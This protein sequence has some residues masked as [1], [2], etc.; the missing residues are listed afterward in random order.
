MSQKDIT[1]IFSEEYKAPEF[2][3][4]KISE[5]YRI[6]SCL[7]YTKERQVYLLERR[8]DKEKFILKC[9]NGR[10]GDLLKREYDIVGELADKSKDL[11]RPIDYFSVDDRHFYIRE[12]AEG[13]TL[14]SMIER[15]VRFSETEICFIMGEICNQVHFFHSQNPPV[16]CRDINPQNIIICEDGKP[17]IIDLDSLREYDKSASS[18]TI[19]V[20]TKEMAA[21]EQFGYTQTNVR[22]D[23]YVLGMLLV[24]ITTG[25]YDKYQ[26]MPV[27]IGRIAAK[28]TSFNPAD[29]YSSALAMKKALISRRKIKPA[30]ILSC[31]AAAIIVTA[32]IIL[33][34]HNDIQADYTPEQVISSASQT[35]TAVT[36][37]QRT[38]TSEASATTSLTTTSLTVTAS[39]AT[40]SSLT[41]A[42]TA[43]MTTPANTTTTF[44]ETAETAEAITTTAETSVATALTTT[45]P[46]TTAATTIIT[47]AN[48]VTTTTTAQISTDT[49]EATVLSTEETKVEF[50]QDGQWYNVGNGT[51]KLY[52]HSAGDEIPLLHFDDIAPESW[53]NVRT[54]YAGVTIEGGIGEC[55]MGGTIDG[56]YRCTEPYNCGEHTATL[57]FETGGKELL[58]PKI[59]FWWAGAKTTITVGNIIFSEEEYVL[60]E[61]GAWHCDESGVYTYKN[62]DMETVTYNSQVL[63]LYAEDYGITNLSDVQKV[64]LDIETDG[65]AKVVLGGDIPTFDLSDELTVNNEKKTLTFETNGN[66]GRSDVVMYFWTLAANVNVRVDNIKFV[67]E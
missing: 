60:P 6:L 29:R 17:R 47:S 3:H 30:V 61:C 11:L 10:N 67:T 7:K 22:T 25:T 15:G 39:A 43:A 54:I 9:G 59:V 26:K 2:L 27:H 14:S 44:S 64:Q 21:P 57:I 32:S 13:R 28:S 66:L 5:K 55:V 20:G 42:A 36:M 23:I 58:W 34:L 38:T 53:E 33:I 37:T 40:S 31:I 50:P 18:D 51:Y 48:T 65:Y 19:C 8:K 1:E 62:I 45:L 16:I 41:A 35:T 4:S 24:Y 49:A 52:H 46:T 56:N 63:R 12:Y